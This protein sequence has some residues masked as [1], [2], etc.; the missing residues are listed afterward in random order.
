M[1][2]EQ[3]EARYK[4]AIAS[5]EK[6]RKQYDKAFLTYSAGGMD[7]KIFLP[8]CDS[9]DKAI[10]HL[11]EL[12]IQRRDMMDDCGRLA[13]HYSMELSKAKALV[14]VCEASLIRKQADY[15]RLMTM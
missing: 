2:I 7:E 3:F 9:Y 1:S 14:S 5:V 4:K 15:H 11:A 12:K 6:T 10:D 13:A 8:I